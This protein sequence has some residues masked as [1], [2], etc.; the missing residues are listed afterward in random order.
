MII[1]LKPEVFENTVKLTDLLNLHDLPYEEQ[2]KKK[3]EHIKAELEKD[4]K[5]V[6][7]DYA[8][9]WGY[10]EDTFTVFRD[11]IISTTGAVIYKIFKQAKGT[12]GTK[13]GEYYRLSINNNEGAKVNSYVHRAV[14]STFIPKTDTYKDEN[15]WDLQVNHKDGNKENNTF[16]NLE[17]MTRIDNLAHAVK[18]GLIP[19]G[20]DHQA[21]QPV[22]GTV[23]VDSEW[24]GT[25]FVIA[26][27]TAIKELGLDPSS[28][29]QTVS[30]RA[31][32][33]YGCN[34]EFI[35]KEDVKWYP[36]PIPPKLLDRMINDR[37]SLMLSTKPLR[38]WLTD[39][40]G[41]THECCFMGGKEC[42]AVGFQQAH[43]SRVC[44]GILK[45]HGGL[46]WEYIPLR[47]AEKMHRGLTDEM[48]KI[49]G[50]E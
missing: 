42:M 24:E 36:A 4:P 10:R 7:W 47:Q 11:T 43:I 45:S 8:V 2:V 21:C 12:G 13:A 30:G 6:A 28:I 18:M 17:W 23:I 34:W 33:T 27:K 41:N 44:N 35:S 5:Y 19:S 49:L 9:A 40:D 37:S 26:G 31:K 3:Y 25:Q 39:K 29:F 20:V 48:K 16:P 50:K 46:K 32:A 14:A 1:D 22:L 38:A 15:I